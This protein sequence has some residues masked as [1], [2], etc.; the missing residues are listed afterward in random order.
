[1]IDDYTIQRIKDAANVVD[2][3]GDFYTLHRDGTGGKYKCLCPFHEDR[4]I[5]SFKVSEARNCYTCF[6][7]GAHGGPV[8]FLM[9]HEK[10]SFVDAIKW[11]GAKYGIQVEGA[12][13]YHPKPATPHA[14][15]PELPVLEL[16]KQM[17]KD[18]MKRQADNT[19]VKWLYSLSW[20]DEQRESIHNILQLY[21][22]G[23]GKEG[24]TV[25]WQVDEDLNVRTAKM[26]LYKA[27]GHRDKETPHNFDFVHSVLLRAGVWDDEKYDYKTCFFGQHLIDCYPDAT[28]NLVESEKTAILCAIAYGNLEKHL[29]IATGGLNFLTASRLKAFVDRKRYIVCYPDRDAVQ[30]WSEKIKTLAYEN[31]AITSNIRSL[32]TAEDGEKADIADVI[33]RL[34]KQDKG[35]VLEQLCKEN[36]IL[37]VLIEK[38]DL[39]IV[40]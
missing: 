26:M 10:M 4:H 33:L 18:L 38:L 37:N 5:G 16:P 24:H 9:E 20:N 7:C 23:N 28:I 19:L 39:E 40:K 21:L 6:S 35:D 29:W 11:L 3:I 15:A 1:M 31:I 27:D 36:P 12:E 22:V 32:Y 25:F 2:V 30:A 34:M 17:V 14:P 13:N 8:D